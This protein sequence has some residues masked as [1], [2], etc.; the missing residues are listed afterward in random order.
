MPQTP[1]G[2]FPPDD[3]GCTVNNQEAKLQDK[4]VDD[5]TPRRLGNYNRLFQDHIEPTMCWSL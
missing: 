1:A 5:D 3:E 2:N 4:T